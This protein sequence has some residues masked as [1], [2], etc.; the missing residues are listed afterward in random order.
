MWVFSVKFPISMT[1]LYYGWIF[2]IRIKNI[3]GKEIRRALDLRP[4]VRVSASRS[5]T[6][7]AFL[8]LIVPG[9][10]QVWVRKKNG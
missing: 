4:S 2:S 5:M 3:I 7:R 10:T 1:L 6:M 9:G 8:Q